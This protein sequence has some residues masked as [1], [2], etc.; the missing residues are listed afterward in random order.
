M[1]ALAWCLANIV[2]ADAADTVVLLHARRPRPVYAAM[3]S[4]GTYVRRY[5]V[6]YESSVHPPM[7]SCRLFLL[8]AGWLQ[9][10][11]SPRTWWRVWRGTSTRRPPSTRPSASA[12]ITRMFVRIRSHC[13][14]YLSCYSTRPFT[15][16]ATAGES[17]DAGGERGHARR[18][19]RHHRSSSQ[20]YGT[21]MQCWRGAVLCAT[22]V[23]VYLIGYIFCIIDCHICHDIF[24]RIDI[25]Y[26]R[27]LYVSK[28]NLSLK[29]LILYIYRPRDIIQYN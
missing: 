17:G 14:S 6:N 13:L 19:L 18:H 28:C 10:I 22:P 27:L 7:L 16:S 15:R 3:D 29:T 1:H 11:C 20:Q 4:A 21:R 23:R 2:P 5:A 25:I 26:C 12:P 24:G 8:P 9:G